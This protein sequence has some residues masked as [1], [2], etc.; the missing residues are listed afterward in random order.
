MIFEELSLTLAVHS[1][2]AWLYWLY[3]YT[4]KFTSKCHSH[5]TLSWSQGVVL[6]SPPDKQ[7]RNYDTRVLKPPSLPN[8][9]KVKRIEP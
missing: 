2:G 6:A 8:N 3:I 7:T 1:Y 4:H 5:T 9:L